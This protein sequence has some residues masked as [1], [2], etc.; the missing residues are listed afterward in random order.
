MG[1]PKET[2]NGNSFLVRNWKW[3]LA[4]AIVQTTA[5]YVLAWRTPTP[6]QI[7]DPGPN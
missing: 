1:V 4:M 6:L 7:M 2:G 3:S 5:S